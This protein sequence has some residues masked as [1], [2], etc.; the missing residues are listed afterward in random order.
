MGQKQSKEAMPPSGRKVDDMI[1]KYGSESVSCLNEWEKLGFPANGSFSMSD[2]EKLGKK[3]VEE[4]EKLRSKKRFKT[5]DLDRI[6]R[7]SECF[8]QWKQEAECRDRKK[9]CK[10]MT[11]LTVTESDKEQEIEKSK[12]VTASVPLIYPAVPWCHDESLSGW[13]PPPPQPPIIMVP[14]PPTYADNNP[15][16][17]QKRRPLALTRLAPHNLSPNNPFNQPPVAPAGWEGAWT[18]SMG[19]TANIKPED[20]DT[21]VPQLPMVQ[22]MGPQGVELVHRPWTLREMQDTLSHL[23]SVRNGGEAFI[24][25]LIDFCQNFS[26][27]EHELK[28]LLTIKMGATDFNQIKDLLNGANRQL[29]ADWGHGDNDHY[30]NMLNALGTRLVARFPKRVDMAKIATCRQNEDESVSDYYTRLYQVFLDNSGLE[31]QGD[32][33]P[34]GVWNTHLR[35]AFLIGLKDKIS[36]AVKTSC[37]CVHEAT[38]IEVKRHAIHAEQQQRHAVEREDKNRKTETHRAQLTMMQSV[39]SPSQR[40]YRG[41]GGFNR[42]GGREHDNCHICGSPDHWM[43]QCPQRNQQRQRRGNGRGNGRSSRGRFQASEG[44]DQQQSGQ[45]D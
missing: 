10:K 36:K 3:L 4:R 29:N 23:P 28:R 31:E 21:Q 18:R 19:A 33:E 30:R 7:H 11:S 27:T 24:E 45:S 43:R 39:S 37:V 42:R 40:G 16:E 17:A 32:T 15:L 5:T 41:G 14:G 12:P 26:P 8:D 2:I 9:M 22:V 25:Q 35:S 44:R 1:K 6:T 34:H 20:A 13:V 38:L